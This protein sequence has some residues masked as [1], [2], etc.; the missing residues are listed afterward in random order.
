[1]K[2]MSSTSVAF[3]KQTSAYMFRLNSLKTC[4]CFFLIFWDRGKRETEIL[5]GVVLLLLLMPSSPLSMIPLVSLNFLFCPIKLLTFLHTVASVFFEECVS[6]DTAMWFTLD[7]AWA[8]QTAKKWERTHKN[9]NTGKFFDRLFTR[10]LHYD[11]VIVERER[12]TR[13][14]WTNAAKSEQRNVQDVGRAGKRKRAGKYG[15][16]R[17][18]IV[19]YSFFILLHFNFYF[20]ISYFSIN[21]Y[22]LCDLKSIIW[23]R[24]KYNKIKFN[25]EKKTIKMTH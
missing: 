14:R 6:R 20:Y 11:D 5:I 8:N 22:M 17:N 15:F 2:W 13:I 10:A 21:I 4:W 7:C 19:F 25:Q 9:N 24:T 18:L 12:C 23:N 1:M 3:D 16:K